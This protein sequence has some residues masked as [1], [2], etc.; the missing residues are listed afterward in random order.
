MPTP[1]LNLIS[2]S[3]YT[4]VNLGALIHMCLESAGCSFHKI[5]AFALRRYQE[6]MMQRVME[7]HAIAQGNMIAN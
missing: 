3:K 6:E 7:L 5:D 4:P 1:H 2:A